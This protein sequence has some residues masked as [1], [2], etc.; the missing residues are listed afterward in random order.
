[1]S[2]SRR[3]DD[4]GSAAGSTAPRGAGSPAV[5]RA[6]RVP[7]SL[8]LTALLALHALG[9][10]RLAPLEALDRQV[11]DLRL[12]ATAADRPDP[13]VAVVDLD[14]RALARHGRWP[15]GRDRLAQMVERLF[16]DQGAVLVGIDLLLSEPDRSS[17]LD[18]LDAL[19]RGPLNGDARLAA[20]LQTLRPV[21]DHDARLADV[22]A[23]HPVV[24]GLQLSD[25][26]GTR[27]G[28]LPPSVQAPQPWP[29]SLPAWPGWGASLA[30]FQQAAAGAGHLN[31]VVDAD[32][33][34][35]RVPLVAVVGDPG[36]G[37]SLQPA[38]ALALV[39]ELRGHRAGAGPVLRWDTAPGSGG[40]VL[41]ALRLDGLQGPL[42]LPV[43]AT[44][45]ALVPYRAATA[46][47]LRVSAADVLDGT[48]APDV[49]RGRVVLVGSSAAGLMDRRATPIGDDLP[50]V[51]VH[52]QLLGGLMDG[53]L[54]QAPA[55]GPVLEATALVLVA[56]VL[57]LVLPRVLPWVALAVGL[58]LAGAVLAA[59]ASAWILAGLA[60]P[61][62]APLVAI[63]L[64]AGVHLMLGYTAE[65][66]AR[67]QLQRLFGHYVPPE[68]VRQMARA[69]HLPT[70]ESRSA[71][72]TV[73]FADLR[74]FTSIAEQ[75]SPAEL[76]ALMNLYFSAMTDVI[77]AHGG[78]LDKYV[79]DAVM[80]FWGAP[81]D[82][83]EH[84]A[85]AVQAA[86]AMQAELSRLNQRLSLQGGPVLA[87]G[88]GLNTGTV[89]VGDFGSRHRRT[90]TVLGD[91]V[92]LA[93][94][95]EALTPQY[96]V[97]IL[98][99][100]ATRRAA[101]DRLAWR[102]VDRVAVRGRQASTVVYVPL[103][104]G[105]GADDGAPAPGAAAAAGTGQPPSSSTSTSSPSSQAPV[106]TKPKR[107]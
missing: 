83:L 96:G 15:W 80:A 4:G 52:A 84:A 58:V 38:F 97:G 82:D 76:G 71:E 88:I 33:R 95:L 26:A 98:C 43:D 7:L 25:D 103:D 94:R 60:V 93:A 100:E 6:L 107:S 45:A 53:R 104:G 49:L 44:G 66:L 8:A 56:V 21:L 61:V 106:D 63:P 64:L 105:V 41:D 55:Y 42:R 72:L 28:P 17:G 69:P 51:E 32:G 70:L 50:G 77:R 99:S 67:R 5:W 75:L 1:M 34:T 86:L 37:G 90:Y 85:H 19:A 87:M 35:R 91:A 14:E 2:R 65:R 9:W 81:A 57:L 22:L 10:W 68:R 3:A 48:L 20:A 16:V 92:N 89:A 54:P 40:R 59:N 101:G 74:G 36:A 78:T 29:D 24:L 30:A 11:Y 47:P 62:A 13:R 79:G 18:T 27:H 39:H 23:R 46:R 102:E 12:Q 31:G 73:M